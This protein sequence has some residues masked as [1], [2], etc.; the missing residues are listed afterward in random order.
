M[1][2]N[3]RRWLSEFLTGRMSRPTTL[4]G[5]GSRKGTN[6]SVAFGVN[7]MVKFDRISLF[8]I[9]SY[10]WSSGSCLSPAW[11][12]NG[13]QVGVQIVKN[14]SIKVSFS[15]TLILIRKRWKCLNG[16]SWIAYEIVY[17]SGLYL[18]GESVRIDK[19]TPLYWRDAIR[20][21]F[22]WRNFHVWSM[23]ITMKFVGCV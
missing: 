5:Y 14:R 3:W 21:S 7:M 19:F 13:I 4:I 6:V 15:E 1:S 22:S 23:R 10:L 2:V 8:A 17:M 18:S 20:T 9:W 11:P 16:F 12:P